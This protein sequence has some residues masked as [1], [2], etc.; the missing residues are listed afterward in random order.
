MRRFLLIQPLG[1][2]QSIVV[3]VPDENV[4]LCELFSQ[5]PGCQPLRVKEKWHTLFQT[6]H[7]AQAVKLHAGRLF[8]H[9]QQQAADL[10]L[11]GADAARACLRFRRRPGSVGILVVVICTKSGAQPGQVFDGARTPAMPSW[12]G[13]GLELARQLV[14]RR[15]TL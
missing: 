11:V 10:E 9:V 13:A 7:V 1:D 2:C 4:F 3:A 6:T 8:Q 5:L 15:R 14:R 12:F